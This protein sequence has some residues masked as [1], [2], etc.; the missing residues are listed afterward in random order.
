[1][2]GIAEFNNKPYFFECVF[3]NLEDDW[4]NEYILTPLTNEIFSLEIS[5]WKY[6]LYWLTQNTIPH[7]IDYAAQRLNESFESISKD[8]INY[9]EWDK[10]EKYYQNKIIIENFLK[11]EVAKIRLK[12]I[13]S[14]R[15]NGSD[16]FVEWSEIK[17]KK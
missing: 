5:N 17:N 7:P 3:S 8:K 12:G 10:A 14:G 9:K 11:T 2:A 15:I 6:W 13:F 1:M 16:T 4:T